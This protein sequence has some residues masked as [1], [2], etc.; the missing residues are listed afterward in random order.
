[1][2]GRPIGR[3]PSAISSNPLI[4]VRSLA[5]GSTLSVMPVAPRGTFGVGEPEG[6]SR[7]TEVG[8]VADDP[9]FRWRGLP[10]DGR[11]GDDA[12]LLGQLGPLHD[13][14]HLHLVVARELGLAEPV[15]VGDGLPRPRRLTRHVDPE[16]VAHGLDINRATPSSARSLPGPRGTPGHASGV[17]AESSRATRESRDSVACRGTPRPHTSVRVIR[18]EG[19]H[20]GR[21]GPNRPL[22]QPH[23]CNECSSS[24][25]TSRSRR[26]WR[27]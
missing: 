16:R 12:F 24:T 22:R 14:D 17:I 9:S 11:G 10:D 6:E 20:T 26:R 25:T 23:G 19:T 13:V 21:T 7:Q 3:P 18:R 2:V 1:M 5:T 4:P 27:S 15:Q 8:Q